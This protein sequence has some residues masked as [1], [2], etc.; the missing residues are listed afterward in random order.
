MHHLRFMRQALG[1]EAGG[2]GG[3]KRTYPTRHTDQSAAAQH[4][5]KARTCGGLHGVLDDFE[6]VIRLEGLDRVP[7]LGGEAAELLDVG[8]G[9]HDVR[10]PLPGGRRHFLLHVACEGKS[11]ELGCVR[12]VLDM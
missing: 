3:A 4:L 12:L 8:R 5:R 1:Q 7:A 6:H 9:Q 2:G 11:F 10:N